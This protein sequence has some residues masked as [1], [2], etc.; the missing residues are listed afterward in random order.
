MW[1]NVPTSKFCRGE[2]RNCS[3]AGTFNPK[4][5]RTNHF[6]NHDF[7]IRYVDKKG[8]SG[9]YVTDDLLFAGQELKDVQ[10]GLGMVSSSRRGFIGLGY[11]IREAYVTNEG[12]NPF[13]NLPQV[14]KNEGLINTEAYSLWLNN[15]KGS[16]GSLLFGGVDTA[17]FHGNLT[18][19]PIEKKHGQFEQF[20]VNL[21]DIHLT[22]ATGSSQFASAES[23]PPL[24]VLLDSGT[25]LMILPK[26]IV[27]NIFNTLKVV[28]YNKNIAV[29]DCGLGQEESTLDFTFATAKIS[30]PMSELVLPIPPDQDGDKT[31]ADDGKPLCRLGITYAAKPTSPLIMGD[32]FLRSAYVVYDIINNEISIAPTNFNAVDSNIV[33]IGTG[34]NTDI[35]NLSGTAETKTTAATPPPTGSGGTMTDDTSSAMHFSWYACAALGGVLAAA[36]ASA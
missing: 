32:T 27:R 35:P 26:E 1:V 9:D 18:T 29:V 3:I 20:Y 5:S 6:I 16:H 19:L 23:T 14:L 2:D 36:A 8:A 33:Q 22:N 28:K 10:F 12:G 15:R 13:P 11:P 34:N 25:T 30:I 24:P 31:T 4:A 17:K 7:R 21:T